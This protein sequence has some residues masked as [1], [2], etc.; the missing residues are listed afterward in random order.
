VHDLAPHIELRGAGIALAVVVT[1]SFPGI[2]GRVASSYW[3]VTPNATHKGTKREVRVIALIGD[4]VR[5]QTLEDLLD[6]TEGVP[7]HKGLETGNVLASPRV[8]VEHPGVDG[9]L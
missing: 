2:S 1:V 6:P 7:A 9:I 4:D 3:F 8:D 5:P